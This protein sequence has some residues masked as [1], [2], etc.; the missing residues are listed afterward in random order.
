MAQCYEL[1]RI[2]VCFHRHG[3]LF[4]RV[5]DLHDVFAKEEETPRWEISLGSFR[6]AD[7]S[8]GGDRGEREVLQTECRHR[9]G[10]RHVGREFRV[11]SGNPLVQRFPSDPALGAAPTPAHVQEYRVD[12]ALTGKIP[13]SAAGR[14]C[15]HLGLVRGH[16]MGTPPNGSGKVS[17]L[18]TDQ[19]RPVLDY[20]PLEDVV[21]ESEFA[22]R[23][24]TE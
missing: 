13:D 12:L 20:K 7:G 23:E 5:L 19:A 6:V 2:R 21:Q 3:V 14:V 1:A 4:K 15:Y 9:L 8:G 17:V 16:P 11:A 10:S 18:A 24:N 22:A